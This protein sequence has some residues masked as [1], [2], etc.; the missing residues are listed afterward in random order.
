MAKTVRVTRAQV[1]AARLKIKRSAVS[2]K[3]VSPSV[4]AVANA[5]GADSPN[6]ADGGSRRTS[7]ATR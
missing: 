5:K 2:G 7:P 1:N 4:H 6:G 3:Y